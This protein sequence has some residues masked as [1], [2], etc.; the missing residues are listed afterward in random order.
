MPQGFCDLPKWT[1]IGKKFRNMLGR[2]LIQQRPKLQSPRPI[3]CREYLLGI[4]A[5]Q[6][7]MA[8]QCIGHRYIHTGATGG[9]PKVAKLRRNIA[10]S[11]L[12]APRSSLDTDSPNFPSLAGHG[13]D[14]GEGLV[15][16]TIGARGRDAGISRIA[17]RRGHFSELPGRIEWPRRHF[18]IRTTGA[19]SMS[20]TIHMNVSGFDSNLLREIQEIAKHDLAGDQRTT[21]AKGILELE[22]RVTEIASAIKVLTDNASFIAKK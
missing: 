3:E 7:I 16:T 11:C 13:R 2:W 15:K 12:T 20:K 21:L 6:P 4:R 17:R 14:R 10:T 18:T 8:S 5:K 9:S 19:L 1:D 22:R